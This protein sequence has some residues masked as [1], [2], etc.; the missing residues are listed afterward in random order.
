MDQIGPDWREIQGTLSGRRVLSAP[1]QVCM[2]RNPYTA[3]PS[4]SY[5]HGG[6]V[7][8]RVFS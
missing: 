2:L 1:R 8:R 4:R 6:L 3:E 5:E 7:S